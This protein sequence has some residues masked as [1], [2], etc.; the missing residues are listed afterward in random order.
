MSGK[1]QSGYRLRDY[2]RRVKIIIDEGASMRM[3]PDLVERYDGC[4][5]AFERILWPKE[6]A[7]QPNAASFFGYLIEQCEKARVY[8]FPEV[9]ERL[10]DSAVHA[11]AVDY[12]YMADMLSRTLRDNQRAYGKAVGWAIIK[13]KMRLLGVAENGQFQEKTTNQTAAFADLLDAFGKEIK[14]E[15]VTVQ[16]G[17]WLY[18]FRHGPLM[19]PEPK[20]GKRASAPDAATCLSVFLFCL[21]RTFVETGSFRWGAGDAINLASDEFWPVIEEA[22]SSALGTRPDPRVVR[23]FTR[24][25]PGA[26]ICGY[27]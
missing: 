7:D 21:I 2:V 14:K 27:N 15:N 8:K 13:A 9:E 1:R 20:E 6:Q 16:T 17:P 25:N 18:R 4:I 19:F 23:Q 22:V 26:T 10:S 3:L 24:R 5:D 11:S 12:A